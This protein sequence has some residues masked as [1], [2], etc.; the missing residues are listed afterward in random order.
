MLGPCRWYLSQETVFIHSFSKHHPPTAC[1]D[2]C[3]TLQCPCPEFGFVSD[4]AHS[5]GEDQLLSHLAMPRN[6]V[7]LSTIFSQA[8]PGFVLEFQL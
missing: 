1:L 6:K 8:S 2:L 5:Q 4:F 3:Q 7:L